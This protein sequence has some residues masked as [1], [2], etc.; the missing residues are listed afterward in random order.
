M[1]EKC[2]NERMMEIRKTKIFANWL[3]KLRDIQ[4]RARVLVRIKRLAEGNTGD[5]KSVGEGVFELRIHYGPGYRV[6]Y[7]KIGHEIVLLLAGG[8]KSTQ[9][10]D[11]RTALRLVHNLPEKN[12]E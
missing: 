1:Q 8:D 10:D 3:D 5:A 6:Y 4:A 7:T 12:H 2:Y 11:I 9:S